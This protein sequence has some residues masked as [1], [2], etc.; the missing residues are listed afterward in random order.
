MF[1]TQALD[2]L[3]SDDV[4][5]VVGKSVRQLD[6]DGVSVMPFKSNG[7]FRFASANVQTLRPNEC[8]Q[9][10]DTPDGATHRSVEL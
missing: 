8:L 9:G 1:N 6:C 10:F 5:S 3:C 2:Y 4:Q 7:V